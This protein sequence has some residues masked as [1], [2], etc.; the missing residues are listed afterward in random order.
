MTSRV[1]PPNRDTN[2]WEEKVPER[3]VTITAVLPLKDT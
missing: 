3:K 2:S 1:H